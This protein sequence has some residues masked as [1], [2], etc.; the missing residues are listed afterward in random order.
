MFFG[1]R[2]NRLATSIRR[3]ISKYSVGSD[4]PGLVFDF[5]DNFYQKDKNQTVNLDGAIT[6]ARAGNATMTDGYGP[7]LV[8]NGGFDSDLSGW[9]DSGLVSNY[10]TGGLLGFTAT[11]GGQGA[12]QSFSTTAGKTYIAT[13]RLVSNTTTAN[14]RLGD[15]LT[16]DAGIKSA[17]L[18]ST[19]IAEVVFT[20][21]SST[22]YVYLRAR[23]AG[24]F[25][26][27]NVS[28]RE[29]PVIKWAPHNLLTYSE[30]LSQWTENGATASATVLTSNSGLNA[31]A[32]Y[33]TF[34][35]TANQKQTF[36]GRIEAGT[37][38]YVNVN[39]Y[40]NT[41]RWIA[42]VFDLTTG[43]V[44]ETA[45]GATS[46]TIDSSEISDNGD[47]SYTYKIVG[48]INQTASTTRFYVG[49][50]E[51]ATGNTFDSAA[52][53]SMWQS[54]ATGTETFTS[55]YATTFRS[56]L[57]GMVNNPDRGDS[58]VPTTSSAKYL[59][60]IG[61]HVYNGSA[62]VNEGVLAESELRVNLV[63][64][65]DF[66]SGWVDGGAGSL[67]LTENSAVS[68]DGT[69][70]AL[71]VESTGSGSSSYIK[72]SSAVFTNGLSPTVSV[73]VKAGTHSIVR[74][75][76]NNSNDNGAWFD[77][78]DG[79]IG[80]DN[81][82]GGH[83]N[84]A[85]IEEVGNGWYRLSRY[86]GSVTT[87]S[88]DIIIGPSNADGGT[89]VAPA[90]TTMYFYGVQAEVGQSSAAAPTASS[91][92]PTS[93]GNGDRAAETFTIPSANL[94]WPEPQY[95]GDE[96]FSG[97]T[98]LG[99]GWTDNGDGSYTSD[100]SDLG[101]SGRLNIVNS[102]VAGTVYYLTMDVSASS[103][104]VRQ[105][106]TNVYSSLTTVAVPIVGDSGGGNI[107]I[108]ANGAL[109]VSNISFR[110]IN[111]LSV[112]IAMDG[113][114][115]YADTGS[116]IEIVPFR[117]RA[118]ASNRI[119]TEL[120]TF[121][122]QGGQLLFAQTSGGTNDNVQS[123]T[124]YYSPDIL[125]PFDI[126]GRHGST[127][128]N[129]AVEGVALTANT[130]P[131]ALPDLSAT[132]LNFAYDFQGTIGTF[133]V[134]DKDLGDDGIVEATNPSLEPS[135]SLTFEGTGTNSFTVSD[136]SE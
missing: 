58:Y 64:Y 30:D 47:G 37:H 42:V 100:G 106:G 104:D 130:T 99:N 85:S 21:E 7:E 59:P 43:T 83:G 40:A 29:M 110:E 75:A 28:V 107:N 56:D 33:T 72:P 78:S 15:G 9:S 121:G 93:G 31:H 89:G 46:G 1:S 96:L 11:A 22:S 86:F 123:A 32:R 90:N 122:S 118:D 67:N 27:D 63:D 10:L 3:G 17:L 114:M 92:I 103:I 16:P 77:L 129:G 120:S 101:G 136:W 60:R 116:F 133:R 51:S 34:D 74:I 49:F 81:D 115:T 61:H 8:T 131:T 68:P 36:S 69:Q 132:D 44:S 5:I 66:S 119:T 25:E 87:G 113:R 134:W 39:I 109:T 50:A 4:N 45:T 20:A 65:S 70:N 52:G 108:T 6:H 55:H 128:I 62:W 111:P 19:G 102:T 91:L 125:V 35:Y 95:I 135:L 79:T 18:D 73:Y 53:R 71:E 84:T 76:N 98:Y 26:W 38:S 124:D 57:G 97:A 82:T 48:S 105:G 126:S 41:A 112:S 127:F 23:A 2:L 14:L 12:Y 24:T 94:P 13:V 117:W 88:N 80:T 54:S